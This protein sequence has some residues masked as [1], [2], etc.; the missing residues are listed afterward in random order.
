MIEKVEVEK[1]EISK[2]IVE[3]VEEEINYLMMID[4]N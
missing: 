4:C 2:E 3:V 1:E